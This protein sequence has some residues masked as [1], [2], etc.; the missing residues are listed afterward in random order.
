MIPTEL[1]ADLDE[2]ITIYTAEP[3]STGIEPVTSC[4]QSARDDEVRCS[5]ARMKWAI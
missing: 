2:A 4:L 1:S 5:E 3:G